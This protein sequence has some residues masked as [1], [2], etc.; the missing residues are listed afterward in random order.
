MLL[1][2]RRILDTHVVLGYNCVPRKIHADY[3]PSKEV[4]WI[5]RSSSN[6][7]FGYHHPLYAWYGE[8]VNPMAARCQTSHST[9]SNSSIAPPFF[10]KWFVKRS[11][12][13]VK[14]EVEEHFSHV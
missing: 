5:S 6:C 14:N 7:L 4:V 11:Q 13:A 12:I 1:S 2:P 8:V 10:V 9:V 3:I